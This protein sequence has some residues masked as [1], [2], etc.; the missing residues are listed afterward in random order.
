MR[1]WQMAPKCTKCPLFFICI[2]T[3]YILEYNIP[4]PLPPLLL[5]LLPADAL[6]TS[7]LHGICALRFNIYLLLVVCGCL[8]MGNVPRV[9]PTFRR[10]SFSD[11]DL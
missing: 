5:L 9:G 8:L 6:T 10:Q 3:C 1:L 4:L 2:M 11:R 7:A